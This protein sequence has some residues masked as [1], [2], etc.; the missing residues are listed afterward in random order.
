[1][2]VV[3]ASVAVKWLVPEADK[4][5]A[6]ELLSGGVTL[7]APALIQVEVAA[8]IARKV[9]FDEI[10]SQEGESALHLWLEFLL[11]GLVTLVPDETDL[12]GA[13]QLATEFRH[14]LQECLYLALA[15]RLRTPLITADR[16]FAGK[17]RAVHPEVRLLGSD[18]F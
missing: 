5:A 14:P 1:M 17:A 10:N 7:L 3:D 8:A 11:N 18:G 15:F 16:K 9:R 4:A 12:A 6:D 2:I 13:W